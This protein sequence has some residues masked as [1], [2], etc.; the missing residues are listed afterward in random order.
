MFHGVDI[1]L[2]PFLA[3]WFDLLETVEFDF[4]FRRVYKLL[5]DVVLVCKAVEPEIAPHE[6]DVSDHRKGV[7]VAD[8]L[9][10]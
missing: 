3:L 6:A 7:L 10:A 8:C 4:V 1:V 2:G 5:L 9:L